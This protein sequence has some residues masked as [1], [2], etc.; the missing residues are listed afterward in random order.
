M[1][2]IPSMSAAVLSLAISSCEEK[3]KGTLQ[4]EASEQPM[5]GTDAPIENSPS[6]KERA[7]QGSTLDDEKPEQRGNGTVPGRSTE[8]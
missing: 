7:I 2:M 3:Q 8:K 6:D 4:R 5:T 1:K